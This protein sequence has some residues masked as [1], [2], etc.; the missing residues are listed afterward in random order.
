M[1]QLIS[2]RGS[3]EGIPEMERNRAPISLAD[4]LDEAV[5]A[6]EL[7]QL[8]RQRLLVRPFQPSD[9]RQMYEAAR[10]SIEQLCEWM[11]WCRADYS[12]K[13]AELFV[14]T[15]AR[16]WQ[17]GEHFS[18]AIIDAQ[19]GT[20]LGSAGLNHLNFTH[21]LGNLGYW[22]RNSANG[23]GV[24]TA[25][26]HRVAEF[27]LMELG[28][29]RLEFLVPALNFASQRVA[30]KVGAKF[31]GVLRERLI[32]GGKCHDAVMYSLVKS[33]LKRESQR[34]TNVSA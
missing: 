22:I 9:A 3:S 15:C 21:K 33:D 30:Q 29:H 25:A 28:L 23:R 2:D 34:G 5:C 18:F 14:S 27:G 20:F 32:I 11:T 31:E 10:A 16:A 26:V 12:I 7:K 24:A 4:R 1:C 19:S 17:K 8:E 13:D 6:E